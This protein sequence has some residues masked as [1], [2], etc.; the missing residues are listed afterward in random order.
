MKT[1]L[2]TLILFTIWGLA[3]LFSQVFPSATASWELQSNGLL[4]KA[5]LMEVM[6]G[7]TMINNQVYQKIFRLNLNKKYH[8]E[9]QS[10]LGMTRVDGLKVWA[11]EPGKTE[12][13]LLYDF[14]LE[15][16]D[17]LDLKALFFEDV[18]L[19]YAVESIE[20]VEVGGQS[21]RRFNFTNGS[22]T[23]EYWIEGVG[24]SNGGFHRGFDTFDYG[25]TLRCF[26]VNSALIYQNSDFEIDLENKIYSCENGK[27]KKGPFLF[28][29]QIMPNPVRDKLTVK[30]PPHSPATIS[31]RLYDTWG[32]VAQKLGP[33]PETSLFEV[34]CSKLSAGIYFLELLDTNKNLSLQHFKVIV[35]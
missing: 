5:P 20:L 24:S 14:D 9:D 10:L 11:I 8:I 26:K 34:D 27:I 3:P 23:F 12:E 32:R 4:G 21:K 13:F 30:L 7:D 18:H 31:G 22:R 33:Y 35:Q 6:C 28:G 16:G 1:K 2:V 19:L 25:V 15:V 29:A 17:S